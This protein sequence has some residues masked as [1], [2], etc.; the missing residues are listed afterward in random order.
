MSQMVVVPMKRKMQLWMGEVRMKDGVDA[1]FF[2]VVKSDCN[3][4]VQPKID[5]VTP[6]VYNCIGL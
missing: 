3:G 4:Y 5:S 6:C 1:Y 2:R